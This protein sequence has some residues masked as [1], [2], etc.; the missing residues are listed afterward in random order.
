MKKLTAP[1]PPK[2][3]S[4]LTADWLTQA[5]R[6]DGQDVTVQSVRQT[7]LDVGHGFMSS[8]IRC[9][10]EYEGD[11]A[12]PPAV[13]A[14]ILRPDPQSLKHARVVDIWDREINFYRTVATSMSIAVPRC[15]YAEA[16]PA[17]EAYA[18]LFDDLS[19]LEQPRAADKAQAELALDRLARMQAQ[20]WGAQ[21]PVLQSI[22]AEELLQRKLGLV[23]KEAL[24]LFEA[25]F[26]DQLDSRVMAAV[27]KSVE[28]YGHGLTGDTMPRT[29]CH[30]DYRPG[31]MKFGGPDGMILLDWQ[32]AVVGQGVYDLGHFIH[33]GMTPEDGVAHEAEHVDYFRDRL[34]AH[35]V[36]PGPLDHF[37][38]QYRR[39]RLGWMAQSVLSVVYDRSALPEDAEPLTPPDY[40]YL[41]PIW[42]EFIG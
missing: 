30:Y 40:G 22:E 8:V 23:I 14:K 42:D 31:N 9:G 5:L 37:M 12:G 4:D 10:L 35:G 11:A 6:A 13:V 26:K 27:R 3:A 1:P 2:E 36:D 7:S 21:S 38:R 19:G 39:S 18:L 28:L 41:M 33:Q 17:R 15:Y 16:D 32:A 24:P 20:F 25:T 29:L 34:S